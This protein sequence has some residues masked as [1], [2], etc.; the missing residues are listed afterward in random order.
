MFASRS[1]KQKHIDAGGEPTDYRDVGIGST[2]IEKIM[3]EARARG[4][5]GQG[6]CP[7]RALPARRVEALRPAL[8]E[9]GRSTALKAGQGPCQVRPERR[10]QIAPLLHEERWQ[11][12]L[13]D[14]RAD[15]RKAVLRHGEALERVVDRG[16]KPQRHDQHLP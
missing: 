9:I 1:L 12:G 15:A 7:A 16:I 10:A 13:G 5:E 6:T 3:G 2:L 4:H 8:L 11:A 14:G